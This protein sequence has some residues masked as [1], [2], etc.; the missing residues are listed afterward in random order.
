MTRSVLL[1]TIFLLSVQFSWG[2][3]GPVQQTLEWMEMGENASEQELQE[4]GSKLPELSEVQRNELILEGLKSKSRS[5]RY[6]IVI[7]ILTEQKNNQYFDALVS[8]AE[9]DPD[10]DVRSSAL[11]T[12]SS[13]DPNRTL[14]VRRKLTAHPD[15]W[16]RLYAL[17]GLVSSTDTADI[18][19]V[20]QAL[21]NDHLM[22]KIGL[23]KARVI[24]GLTVDKKI[25]LE[26]L[27]VNE[28][29][30]AAHP[31]NPTGYLSRRTSSKQ[32]AGYIVRLIRED[33]LF[34]LEKKGAPEDIP[35]LEREIARENST[36]DKKDF[37][38]RAQVTIREIQLMHLPDDKK[39][40]YLHAKLREPQSG[41]RSWAAIK[42]CKVKGGLE[43]I[44]ALAKD[45]SH[46][47]Y[48]RVRNMRLWCSQH[49][50]EL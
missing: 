42:L 27:A 1:T 19:A 45:P 24:G 15:A 16:G 46:P 22:V 10:S 4:V 9:N 3:S 2:A 6:Q 26:G 40:D 29:W 43:V 21:E 41:V 8:V 39:L 49:A 11:T 18:R 12:M 25:A 44:D 17:S 31:I 13:I 20:E 32:Y 38:V 47:A 35:Q 5:V 30:F 50:S 37:G 34:V 36:G 23:A 28:K 48:K 33:A 14:P 7:K